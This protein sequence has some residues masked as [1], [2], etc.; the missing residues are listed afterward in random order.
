MNAQ[1]NE[2]EN[3]YFAAF[4]HSKNNGNFTF[5]SKHIPVLLMVFRYFSTISPTPSRKLTIHTKEAPFEFGFCFWHNIFFLLL[6]SFILILLVYIL[7]HCVKIIPF[8][9][10]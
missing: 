5:I 8:I 4:T 1:T 2:H 7:A 10:S 9:S 6:L 3:V